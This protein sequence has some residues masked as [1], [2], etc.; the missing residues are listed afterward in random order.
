MIETEVEALLRSASLRVTRPRVAVL[1]VLHDAPHAD[2]TTVESLVRERIGAVSTQA[3]YDVLKALV[4]A[5]I[6]RR[7]DLPGSPARY[8]IKRGDRHQHVVCRSCGAIKDVDDAPDLHPGT[9]AHDHGFA[10]E[11]VEVTYW[12]LCPACRT[13]DREPDPHD[14]TRP[15][16]PEG[17]RP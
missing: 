16:T 1:S 11:G 3:V 2:V 13:D 12:G 17:A 15:A 9:T 6:A 10:I 14:P 5:D 4:D 7:I 8:E